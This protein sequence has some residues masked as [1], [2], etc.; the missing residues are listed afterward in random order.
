MTKEEDESR[1]RSIDIE[2]EMHEMHDLAMEIKKALEENEAINPKK[3]EDKESRDVDEFLKRQWSTDWDDRE[4]GL[5]EMFYDNDQIEE[6]G[7]I[8]DGKAVGLWESFH[9]N[10][11][12][13]ER[14]NFKDGE[15]NGLW[16][17]FDEEGNLI[18]TEDW[19]DGELI[20]E[21]WIGSQSDD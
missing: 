12:L 17:G 8:K 16:E 13:D 18:Y 20:S 19:K 5:W 1:R 15:L 6:R 3:K 10:G 21:N 11:Q 9:E 2:N 14:G 4:D 7:N